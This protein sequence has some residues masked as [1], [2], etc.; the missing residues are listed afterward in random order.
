M[1]CHRAPSGARAFFAICALLALLPSGTARSS[2]IN[3]AWDDCG[4]GGTSVRS[5][6]CNTNDGDPW[7]LVASFVPP[8]DVS[9]I[10]GVSGQVRISAANLP[11]WW[12]HGFGQCRGGA[13]IFPD[14]GFAPNGCVNPWPGSQIAD[15]SYQ[16]DASDPNT[17]YLN[18]NVVIGENEPVAVSPSN[19]YLGF[20][21]RLL[22]SMVIGAESCAGCAEPVRL[23]L[24]R[25]IL[26]EGDQTHT[27]LTSPLDPAVAYWQ[28]EVGAEPQISSLSPANGAPGT[29]VEIDGSDLSGAWS[30]RFNGVAA[31]FVVETDS[32]IRA[33]VP[34]LAQ[35]GQVEVQTPFGGGLS[36]AEFRVPP[37]IADLLPRQA[38]TGSPVAIRGV[39]LWGA[40]SV[41]FNGIPAVFSVESS[42][43]IRATV[44]AGNASGTVEVES[45][46]GTGS[47]AIAFQLGA[48]Q[49]VFNLSWDDCGSAGAELAT[50]TC[51]TNPGPF[52]LLASF[53]PPPGID[54]ALG[55]AAELRLESET[56]P[57]FWSFAGQ[58]CRG[59]CVSVDFTG[60]Q[61]CSDVWG[62]GASV[63]R[64]FDPGYYGPG[65]ARLRVWT[66][67]TLGALD[68]ATEYYAFRISIAVHRSGMSACEN[69]QAPIDFTLERIEIFE[70]L[71]AITL[72]QS[73]HT[74]NTARWEGLSSH[75]PQLTGFSPDAGSPGSAVTLFGAHLAGASS[76]RFAESEAT[77]KVTSDTQI[78]ATVPD[79]A[80]S[81]PIRVTTPDG[82]DVTDDSFIVAPRITSFTPRQTQVG[83]AVWI[84]GENFG[85]ATS[86]RFHNNVSAQFQVL[87]DEEI[88]AVVPAGTVD[89]SI[90]V[91]NAGGSSTSKLGFRVGDAPQPGINLAWDDCGEGGQVLKTFACDTNVGPPI[92]LVASFIPPPGVA[93]F[94]GLSAT[95]TFRSNSDL[96]P[97]WW[98]HGP[99]YCRG[100]GRLATSFD[101]RAGPYSC[102]DVFQGLGGGGFNYEPH[103][104]TPDQ[105]RLRIQGAIPY[106][107][108]RTVS[109]NDEYF[110]FKVLIMR[111]K[112]TGEGACAGCDVPLCIRLDEIQLFQPAG[113]DFDPT[114]TQVDLTNVVAWQPGGEGC[115]KT[116]TPVLVSLV[117]ADATPERVRLIWQTEDIERASVHRREGSAEW[118]QVADLLPD[119]EHRVSYEDTDIT[120]GAMYDYRLGISSPAGEVY[121]GET[122][123]SIPTSAPTPLSLARVAWNGSALA[124]SLSLPRA[125]TA[126]FEL[127][128]VH[129]RRV[130]SESIEGL[131]AGGHD[132][133]LRPAQSLRPGV[134]FARLIQDGQGVNRRFVVVE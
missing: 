16:P 37:V 33:T 110:G 88:R 56:F 96:L 67:Q 30:V 79:A 134:L 99:S 84:Q 108:M 123:V 48:A 97:D 89:G 62:D 41:T 78:Q 109:D 133:Q 121:L 23:T 40:T 39:N 128:D 31:E 63:F 107:N 105:A 9:N 101:F 111:S 5:F 15:Y 114:I 120:P 44:P 85:D 12:K 21:L 17:A 100:I 4:P 127:F 126:S 102:Q 3:L 91:Q 77:F 24:Q 80:R 64:E 58:P 129:G 22:P 32:R 47:S 117:T 71:G 119:G 11:D 25:V 92:A 8:A 75:A 112:T 83:N 20:A 55:I 118:R 26:H 103:Y 131:D 14:V 19:E 116:T 7:T 86:V 65:T 95:I 106:E 52:P 46:D 45:P 76:V 130:M 68:P 94:V 50:F 72:L 51:T 60:G 29:E 1:A 2:D 53:V 6:A 49:G 125:G 70:D 115:A 74:R 69:T 87:S 122:R 35:T 66:Y 132:L 81:G 104:D 38:P 42:S 59:L 13:G 54:D 73:T 27:T 34:P 43:L 124:V 36:A 98:R 82:T 10:I 90:V 57:E 28:S 18:V 93:E 61:A 113:R